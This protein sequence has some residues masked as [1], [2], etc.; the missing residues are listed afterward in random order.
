MGYELGVT[1]V[2][3]AAAYGAIANDGLLLAPTLVR[4]VRD[5]SGDVLFRRE[6]E[7]VRRVISPEIAARL[8]HYLRGAVGEGGTGG[9][10]QLVNYTVLGKTGTARRFEDGRYAAGKYTSTLRRDLP[11]G[12]PPARRDREDRQPEGELLRRTDGR[13][14]HPHDAAAGARLA[15]G[16]DRSRAAGPA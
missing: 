9:E 2:Q 5:P 4:E 6:P 11:G 14:G 15:T 12:R 1:P 3:L 7:P 13:P 16:R 8:R 10:A